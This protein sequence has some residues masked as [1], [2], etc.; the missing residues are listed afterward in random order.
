MG[1]RELLKFHQFWGYIPK[2]LNVNSPGLS[3]EGALPRVKNATPGTVRGSI[4]KIEYKIVSDGRNEY[5]KKCGEGNENGWKRFV[6]FH[7]GNIDFT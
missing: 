3:D 6:H 2:G 7:P 4:L 5:R 1:K